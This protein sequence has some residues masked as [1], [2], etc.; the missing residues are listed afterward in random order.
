MSNTWEYRFAFRINGAADVPPEFGLAYEQLEGSEGTPLF[1]LF[2]PAIEQPRRMTVHWLPPKLI[3]VFQDS[4]VVFSLENRSN[5]ISTF[6]RKRENVL[7]CGLGSFLL[8]TWLV[9]CPGDPPTEKLQIQFPSQA[10]KHYHDLLRFLLRW[11]DGAPGF[12]LDRRLESYQPMPGLP[13][14][15]SA[16][17]ESYP[18]LG[19]ASEFFFQPATE[20]HKDRNGGWAN[21]LLAVN[22]QGIVSLSDQY[23][24]H[25]SEYG[26]EMTFFPLRA[27]KHADWIEPTAGS[28]ARMGL[29]LQGAS[30]S[31]R[32]SLPVFAGLKPYGL[33]WIQGVNSQLSETNRKPVL[34]GQVL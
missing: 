31:L 17:L 25:A 21:L 15:F 30:V 26:A 10:S 24:D 4:L 9:L 8:N 3:L 1:G 13:P 11:C 34:A 12:T 6:K 29:N 33:R 2:T 27:V 18:E 22:P 32:L 23:H 7:G 5:Q 14:K 20:L 28:G 19:G 16:F